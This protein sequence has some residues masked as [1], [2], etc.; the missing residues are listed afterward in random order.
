MLFPRLAKRFIVSAIAAFL[1]LVIADTAIHFPL[2]TFLLVIPIAAALT[3][4]YWL[5]FRGTTVCPTCGGTGKIRV[6]GGYG[7]P[8]EDDYCYSCDGEGRVPVR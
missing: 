1:A 2:D 5:S 8:E 4:L 3:F 7:Y 6:K